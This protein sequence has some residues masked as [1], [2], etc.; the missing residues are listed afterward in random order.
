MKKTKLRME[1]FISPSGLRQSALLIGGMAFLL[2]AT[3]NGDLEYKH[4]G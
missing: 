1:T 3:V 2:T 4:I